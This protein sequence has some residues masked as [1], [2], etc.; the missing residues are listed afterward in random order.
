MRH[1]IERWCGRH[2]RVG[3]AEMNGSSGR[4]QLPRFGALVYTT[5]D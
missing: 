3:G 1:A 4:M 5:Y 2:H